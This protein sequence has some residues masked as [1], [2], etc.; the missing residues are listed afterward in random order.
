MATKPKNRIT[1]WSYS[2]WS[3]YTKCPFKLKCSALLRIK[4]P[5]GKAAE[6]GDWIHKKG[7]QFLLGNIR[8]VPPEYKL[9]DKELRAIKNLGASSEA[10]LT[11]TKNFGSPTRGDDWDG[12]WCRAKGDA[13]VK[14]EA[15]TL[16]IIDFKTGKMYDSHEDQG[17]LY[18]VCGLVH[19]PEVEEVDVEFWYLDSGEVSVKMY[20]REGDFERLKDK[21]MERAEP[22]LKDTRFEPTPSDECNRCY[23]SKRKNGP[24]KY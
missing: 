21:W 24:C 4:E 9:F 1:G 16:S 8:G 5:S 14:P 13:L 12:A 10:D 20:T 19:E 22:M 17:E 7:E 11:T 6:R 15:S 2:R 23:Y 18:V 3:T